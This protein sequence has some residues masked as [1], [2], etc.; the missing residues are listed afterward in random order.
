MRTAKTRA[1]VWVA[2]LLEGVRPYVRPW[3]WRLAPSLMATAG[4]GHQLRLHASSGQLHS[5]KR[6]VEVHGPRVRHG[7]FRGMRYEA[8]RVAATQKL[9]GAYE[10]ELHPW[11]ERV[12]A[13][14]PTRF[15]DIG[16]ADGYYAIGIARRD[17]P[18]PGTL[19]S[20]RT[21]LFQRLRN[22]PS[23]CVRFASWA[24]A[25]GAL[26]TRAGERHPSGRGLQ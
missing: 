26:A 13:Q 15:V 21:G 2:D 25:E 12:L 4:S 7:P 9:I 11:L 23:G 18:A 17:I 19:R 22:A 5:A 16:A 6:F 1:G 3:A 8:N 24:V 14:R 10:R 20:V